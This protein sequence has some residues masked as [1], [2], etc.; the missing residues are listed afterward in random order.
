MTNKDIVRQLKLTASLLELHGANPFK[1]KAYGSAVFVIERM[2]EPLGDKDVAEMVGLGIT[3]GMATK[4]AEIRDTNAFAE[5]EEL[6]EQ[7]P[8]GLLDMLQIKGI[9]AKKIRT[10][11]QE[12]EIETVEG[13][14]EASQAGQIAK[15]NGFGEKTQQTIIDQI[16]YIESNQG[17]LLY[18]KAELFAEKLEAHLK[19]ELK[20]CEVSLSGQ[21]RM[22]HAIIEKLQLV[23]GADDFTQVRNV[24]N[25]ISDLKTHE[26]LS[27]PLVWRGEV[28]ENTLPVE[29]IFSSKNNFG[30][31]L[32]SQSA[33]PKHLNTTIREKKI[34]QLLRTESFATEQAIYDR[35]ELPFIQPELREGSFELDLARENKLPQLLTY[36]DLKGTVHNHSTYSDGKHTLAEMAVKAKELGLEYL[37]I[38]DHSKTAS[39]ANGLSEE[40]IKDQHAEIDELNKKL[41]PFKILKGI[42]SDILGDGSL[43]YSD[44]VLASFDFIVSSIH[45][46]LKMDETK[47][48]ERL[49]GA[50]RNPYTSILGH[51]TGR[52]LLKR[53]GY[54]ID[55]KTVIDACAEHNVCIEI[56]ANPLRLDLDWKWVHYALSKK[57]MI[58]INPDAHDKEKYTDMKYGVLVGRKAGLT[59]EMTL[60]AMSLAEIE[61]W[62]GKRNEKLRMKN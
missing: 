25:E 55:H 13:L 54:P 51:P 14:M 16:E 28:A 19:A 49:L 1:T 46:N 59:K 12:L 7:T 4:I 5:L 33:S 38:S 61:S 58:A 6:L 44:E 39:Y 18:S 23:V 34:S 26:K 2:Q 3:K 62:L 30:N 41:A 45:A 50:I 15:L 11:W 24:L 29:V 40:R 48:T 32:I 9:G 37:G 57:V 52:L 17:K 56:N 27:G 22:N 8:K 47:A 21:F 31:E 53:E 36:E 60:N 20:D 42:E 35:L 43:D 10:I